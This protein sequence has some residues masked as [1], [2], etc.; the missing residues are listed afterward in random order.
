MVA[1]ED[2]A[3]FVF[4]ALADEPSRT[5]RNEPHTKELYPR[6]QAL[7][8]RREHPLQVPRLVAQRAKADPGGDDAAQ[9]PQRIIDGGD[10]AAVSRVGDLGDEQRTRA[11]G[12]VGTE[13]HDETTNEVHGVTTCSVA[14]LR[15]ALQQGAENYKDAA[16]SCAALSTESVGNVWSEEEDEEAAETGHG[17]KDA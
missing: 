5:L 16:Q 11:I 15:E 1:D 4:A 14:L 9:V 17:A 12:D 10:G 7:Q 13:A 2:L 8:A 3:C 6:H